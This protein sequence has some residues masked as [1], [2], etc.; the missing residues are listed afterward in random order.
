MN[1]RSIRTSTGV[2]REITIE[3]QLRRNNRS[4]VDGHE[5]LQREICELQQQHVED[6]EQLV[7]LTTRL[8][9]ALAESDAAL[10]ELAALRDTVESLRKQRVEL[11]QDVD[12]LGPQ[13]DAA[14]QQVVELRRELLKWKRKHIQ[15]KDRADR[16]EAEVIEQGTRIGGLNKRIAELERAIKMHCPELDL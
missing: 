9:V 13:R 12:M 7:S 14:E 6:Q 15:A 3:E 16:F 10:K 4:L 11:L 1:T 8:N 5:R 2:P